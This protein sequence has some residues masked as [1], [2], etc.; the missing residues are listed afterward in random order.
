MTDLSKILADSNAQIV[1]RVVDRDVTRGE[2]SKAFDSVADRANWKNPINAV[3]A[4][5]SFGICLLTE[6]VIFFTGSV[7]SYKSLGGG[8][9]RVT[10][11][12]YYRT[13]GA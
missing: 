7:P 9:Y 1:A 10:A 5:D 3:V 11:A 4:L 12:G 8:K 13:I 6:A 2:L